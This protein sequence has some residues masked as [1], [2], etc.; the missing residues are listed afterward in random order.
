VARKRALCAE[1]RRR[2]AVTGIAAALLCVWAPTG[3]LAASAVY[4]SNA[5][6]N[7]I[8]FANLDASAGGDLAI[9]G[10]TVD[11]PIGVAVDPAAGRI[12]WANEK[13]NEISFANLDGSGGGDLSVGAAT[14]NGPRGVAID[15]AAGRIYWANEKGSKI[16]FANLNGVGGGDLVTTGATVNGPEGV[17]LDPAAGLIYWADAGGDKISFAHLDGSGGTDLATLTATVDTP[18][19][20]ALL[21]A[22]SGAGAPL[23]SGGSA[24]GSELSCSPGSWAPDVPASFFYR[25]PQ[26]FAY[27]WSRNGETIDGASASSLTAGVAGDYRCTVSATNQAGSAAQTSAAHSVPTV[28]PLGG[29]GPGATAGFGAETLVTLKLGVRRIAA[30]GPLPVRIA[31]GNSF[32]I[33]G[34]LSGQATKK[35]RSS[36]IQRGGL[37]AKSFKL[38]AYATATV[39]LTLPQTLRTLLERTHNLSLA[40]TATVKDPAGN[41]R[42]VPKTVTPRLK[43]RHKR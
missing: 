7:K 17:A 22:P 35:G 39:R 10:A 32:A 23:V 16:S 12:Y 30:G 13:G 34:T 4:W 27:S 14:L 26:S 20:P 42:T 9:T 18:G 41:S 24:P 25:A 2:L 40:L 8:S 3:A 5:S 15:P 37:K 11:G 6:S 31:N 43:T 36:R 28:A 29:G 19:F 38:A 1:A 33:A 21:K